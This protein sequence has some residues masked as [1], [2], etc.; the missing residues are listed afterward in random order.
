[1]LELKDSADSGLV[2]ASLNNNVQAFQLLVERHQQAVY[3]VAYA[4]TGQEASSEDIAQETFLAAWQQ[5]HGLREPDKVRAWLCGISRM[6][7]KNFLRRGG[8]DL[9]KGSGPLEMIEEFPAAD[10]SPRDAAEKRERDTMVWEAL[11]QIPEI[12]REPIALYYQEEQ[13]VAA[14]A[15]A[16][17]LSEETVKQR[18]S[19]G[20]KML[21]DRL[22]S[23]F[24]ESLSNKKLPK[25]F[26]VTVIAAL[27]LGAPQSAAAGLVAKSIVGSVPVLKSSFAASA[28]VGL[29]T[30]ILGIWSGYHCMKK[31]QKTAM[32][33]LE[34][35]FMK[36]WSWIGGVGICGFHIAMASLTIASYRIRPD[37]RFYNAAPFL[38]CL[39][40]IAYILSLHYGY[41]WVMARHQIIR[42]QAIAAEVA[43]GSADDLDPSRLV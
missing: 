31:W 43:A 17:N 7:S 34:S 38:L 26:A 25:T 19:R 3:A 22:D 42:Q 35:R 36:R 16:L 21:R 18:L 29:V 30:P 6:L 33:A 40:W 23:W 1:M 24:Q 15:S 39:I 8:K 14:V 41:K 28:I 2:A 5:L 13:S 37:T 32:S 20:R 12:Y 4:V 11:E 10:I 9:L 27:P